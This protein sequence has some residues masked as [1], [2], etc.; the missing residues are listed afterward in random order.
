MGGNP[1]TLGNLNPQE[2]DE[3]KMDYPAHV[4]LSHE[5][6]NLR[7]NLVTR[8]TCSAVYN[9]LRRRFRKIFQCK[10]A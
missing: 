2:G 1:P 3:E 4:T 7:Y 5:R 9:R 10:N 6:Y 8:F